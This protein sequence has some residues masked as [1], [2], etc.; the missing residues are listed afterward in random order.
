MRTAPLWL[1]VASMIGGAACAD[2]W[3]FKDLSEGDGGTDATATPADAN[4]EPSVGLTDA[5]ASDADD[6]LDAEDAV[7]EGSSDEAG[8]GALG[9]GGDAAALVAACLTSCAIGCCD[10]AG[11]CQKGTSTSACG[12]PGHVCAV[13]NANCG[14]VTSNCCN[15]SQNCTCA[16]VCL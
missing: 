5:G 15:S 14:F 11:K 9:D 12:S 16:T 7:A 13:C 8:D 6:S 4:D 3:G 1:A 2:V 10:S